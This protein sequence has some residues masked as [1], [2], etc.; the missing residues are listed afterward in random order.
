MYRTCSSGTLRRSI[1]RN[2]SVGAKA[3]DIRIESTREIP[4]K[5][6][7]SM[8]RI[9]TGNEKAVRAHLILIGRQ[10]FRHIYTNVCPCGTLNFTITCKA[11]EL[12]N[13]YH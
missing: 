3:Q 4:R 10:I 12:F 1:V 9:N 6:P 5:I 2:S 7:H 8:A 13:T 11:V